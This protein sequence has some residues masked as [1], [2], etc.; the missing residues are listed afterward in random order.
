MV[1]KRGRG[2]LYPSASPLP[3]S[4]AAPPD[5]SAGRDPPMAP[6]RAERLPPPRPADGGSEPTRASVNR[7]GER[8]RRTASRI[9]T[10]LLD[11]PGFVLSL[12]V[13]R[14]Q[15]ENRLVICPGRLDILTGSD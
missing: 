5:V 13:A 14:V 1:V 2:L 15:L 10:H 9:A 12:R 11:L 4:S 3:V 6:R 7:E 8:A